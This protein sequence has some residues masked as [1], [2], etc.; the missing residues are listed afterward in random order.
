M[1]GWLETTPMKL[2]FA[3]FILAAVL[4]LSCTM[5]FAA[6]AT[7]KAFEI[8]PGMG[9][10]RT[11]GIIVRGP[12]ELGDDVTLFKIIDV[13]KQAG[14]RPVILELDSPGG[15]V[16]TAIRIADYVFTHDLSTT[17]RCGWSCLSACSLM[18]FA[19]QQWVLHTGGFL[20]V[21]R[22]SVN[23]RETGAAERPPD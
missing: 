1:N 13:M 19:G 12:I 3:V 8:A 18:F 11:G 15:N 9:T 21:H 2:T 16:V 17:I 6:A 22:A 23:G 20:G 10:I 7:V 5:N 14:I 4:A